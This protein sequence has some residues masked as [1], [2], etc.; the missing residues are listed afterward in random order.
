MKRNG[1]YYDVIAYKGCSGLALYHQDSI[2]GVVNDINNIVKR[3]KDAGYNNNEKW[4]IVSVEWERTFIG[5]DI[6][7][8]SWEKRKAVAFYDNGNVTVY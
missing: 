8:E 2:E 6:F 3:A 5:E 7:L 1:K 4:I